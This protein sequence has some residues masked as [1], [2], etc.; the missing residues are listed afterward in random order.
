MGNSH[1]SSAYY[2][3]IA[4]FMMDAAVDVCQVSFLTPYSGTAFMDQVL[5]EDRLLC[6][7]FPADWGKFNFGS[8]VQQPEGISVDDVYKGVNYVKGRMSLQY[9]YDTPPICNLILSP[10]C[11]IPRSTVMRRCSGERSD[12]HDGRYEALQCGKGGDGQE[13]DE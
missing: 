13:D 11:E 5:K 7:N 12:I 8:M 6:K 3:E 1:E 4:D 2:R 10:L 9:D